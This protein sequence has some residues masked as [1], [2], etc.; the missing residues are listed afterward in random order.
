MLKLSVASDIR[1][2]FSKTDDLVSKCQLLLRFF[3]LLTVSIHFTNYF[4]SAIK[5]VDWSHWW[6]WTFDNPTQEIILAAKLQGNLPISHI[7]WLWTNVTGNQFQL[8]IFQLCD[9]IFT[10]YCYYCYFSHQLDVNF[11]YIV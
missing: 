5:T 6:S 4:N 8:N 9:N 3:V 11:N 1:D 2:N 10:I 7:H